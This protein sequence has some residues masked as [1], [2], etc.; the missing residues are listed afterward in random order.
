MSLSTL[1]AVAID[2][3]MVDPRFRVTLRDGRILSMPL[4]WFLRLE[5]AGKESLNS[6]RFIGDGEGI[7]RAESDEDLSVASLLC[8]V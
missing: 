8:V 1:D 5:A 4:S 2:A 6:W 7:R 3:A